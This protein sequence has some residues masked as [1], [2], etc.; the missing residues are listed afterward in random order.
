M[1]LILACQRHLEKSQL[2][3]CQAIPK[4]FEKEL[5]SPQHS[6]Q[7]TGWVRLHQFLPCSFSVL[8]GRKW[9]LPSALKPCVQLATSNCSFMRWGHHT[10]RLRISSYTIT[11]TPKCEYAE[12]WP[13]CRAT[14]APN[15]IQRR[16]MSE[17][18]AGGCRWTTCLQLCGLGQGGQGPHSF[19]CV[20]VP[21][22]YSLDA[23]EL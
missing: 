14:G 4:W 13:H 18:K 20:N 1:V 9:Q 8:Q 15:I 11:D 5:N 17:C 12:E 7:N 10:S 3:L 16:P 21:S 19:N 2:A 22:A 6:S 23:K